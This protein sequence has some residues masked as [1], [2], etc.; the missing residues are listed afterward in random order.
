MELTTYRPTMVER[1]LSKG[2]GRGSA[3][4]SLPRHQ[5]SPNIPIPY[6]P[7]RSAL[8][9]IF[10]WLRQ[11]P[12]SIRVAPPIGTLSSPGLYRA[13]ALPQNR[14]V[15]QVNPTSVVFQDNST[16]RFYTQTLYG[17]EQDTV[18]IM[19]LYTRAAHGAQ[20]MVLLAEIEMEF[21]AGV[22]SSLPGV[23]QVMLAITVLRMGST[24]HRRWGQITM[25]LNLLRRAH[26]WMMQYVP[27]TYRY[28]LRNLIVQ[29]GRHLPD[30]VDARAIARIA[31]ILVGSLGT[32]AL[33]AQVSL[34][35][36]F[37][38]ALRR[39]LN[40]LPSQTGSGAGRQVRQLGTH[41]GRDAQRIMQHFQAQGWPVA[42]GTAREIAQ[43]CSRN[44]AT[45]NHINEFMRGLLIIAGLA[46][47]IRQ[48]ILA[49]SVG[50]P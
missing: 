15:L 42:M 29:V 21:L 6:I 49:A 23:G 44:P 26:S 35:R 37:L 18:H 4:R 17:F 40:A 27:V 8:D 34:I 41:I 7:R 48:D 19:A 12:R 46:D 43:E 10:Y 47:P 50:S 38:T 28:I 11:G 39:A 45:S 13:I 36:I 5:P 14:F 9:E 33:R 3:P 24:I 22:L 20:G 32:A 25:A 31:G 2:D 30:A 16:G 1:G